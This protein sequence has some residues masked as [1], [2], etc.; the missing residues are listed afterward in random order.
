M[1]TFDWEG[2]L[3]R[4]AEQ[5]LESMGNDQPDLSPEVIETGWLGYSGATEA[6]IAQ[7]EAH[8]GI[9]L[10]PSYR[11]FLKVT[12]GWRQT[13]PFINRLWSTDEI[14]WFSRRH[15]EWI[16]A[17]TERYVKRYAMDSPRNGSNAA[18]GNPS[19]SD[20]EYFVYGEQQDC[21]KLRVD[22]L[23]TALEISDRGDS[24]IYLLNP[25]VKTADGEWE[26]W[27]FGDWLP[28][29]DRYRSFREM[30]QAE[31]ANFLEQIAT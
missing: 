18:L 4:W 7:A 31:Y 22:Y 13:T 30:M 29:A 6:Q 23:K 19:I 10:P 14:E 25:R 16:D 20:Q 27:F 26:A 15:Q 9:A 3:K 24:A 1:S 17:F 28:G 5:L 8:L 21:S 2:F 12:N 11:A